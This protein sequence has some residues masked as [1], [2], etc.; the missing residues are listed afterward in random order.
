MG[1]CFRPPLDHEKTTFKAEGAKVL[2]K[3]AEKPELRVLC[4][5]SIYSRVNCPGAF[6]AAFRPMAVCIAE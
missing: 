1:F 2:A 5:K 3:V 6:L 4:V